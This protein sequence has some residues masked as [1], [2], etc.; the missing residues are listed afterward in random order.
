MTLIERRDSM[1]LF[2]DQAAEQ[3]E[4]HTGSAWRQRSGS[5]G[6]L[7]AAIDRGQTAS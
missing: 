1:E 3:F 7:T 5:M 4:R 2:R 6:T